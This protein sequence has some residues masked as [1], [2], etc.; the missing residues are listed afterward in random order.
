MTVT[1]LKTPIVY[2]YTDGKPMA[3]SDFTRD[4]LL[5]GVD[6]L[7]YHFRNKKNIYVSGN[8]FIYYVENV[9][10]A[11]VAPDVFLV[12]GVSNKK[13]LSYK[14][15]EEGGLTPDWVLEVTS[16]STRNTDEEEK[17]WKY[18]QMGVAEYFQYDPT[19]DYLRPH[20]L[21]G[22]SLVS[23]RYSPKKPEVLADGVLSIHSEV[24]GLDLRVISGE[25]R[26]YDPVTGK[27]LP[28]YSE[29][30]SLAEQAERQLQ[31]AI[32]RLLEMGLTTA[33]VASALGLPIDAVRDRSLS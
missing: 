14:V 11:V 21:K 15:W 10:D 28:S 33:Q 13:R 12:K 9:P 27:M 4:Y 17:P 5:Y 8:L 16:A 20:Q 30:R 6:V 23:G 26:F 19:G 31:D 25:L 18:A 32:P 7:Q 1:L 24:L 29:T 2:P 22:A 3:E